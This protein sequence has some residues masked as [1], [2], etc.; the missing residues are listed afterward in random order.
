MMGVQFGLL[1]QTTVFIPQI[2]AEKRDGWPEDAKFFIGLTTDPAKNDTVTAARQQG[3][4][5][6]PPRAS[7]TSSRSTSAASLEKFYSFFR[8]LDAIVALHRR[9]QPVRWRNRRR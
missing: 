4:P 8:I 1:W 7:R 5:R 3:A 6:E 2:T 9:H